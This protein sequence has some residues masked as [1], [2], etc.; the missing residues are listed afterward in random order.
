MYI[1]KHIILNMFTPQYNLRSLYDVPCMYIFRD[2]Y[3]VLV[4]QLCSLPRRNLCLPL[5]A[6]LS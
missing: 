5:S 2:N 3:L 6:F 1:H 4:N